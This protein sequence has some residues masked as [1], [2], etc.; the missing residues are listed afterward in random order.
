MN[1]REIG[2]KLADGSFYPVLEQSFI[3]RKKL[4]VTTVRDNQETVQIDLFQGKGAKAEQTDYI[5]SLVIENIH[6][7]PRKEPEIEVVL[8]VDN[9]GNLDATASDSMTGEK[10]SIS[11][12]LTS[13]GA[14]EFDLR[15]ESQPPPQSLEADAFEQSLL[16]GETYPIG[17]SD[18]RKEHLQRKKRS[19]LLLI[20]FILLCLVLIAALAYLVFRLLDGRPIPQLFGGKEVSTAVE[21]PAAPSAGAQEGT[22]PAV[23]A[24]EKPAVAEQKPAAEGPKTP[25]VSEAPKAA[26]IWYMI[27]WGDTLWDL[28]ATYYRNPWLYPQLAKANNIVNPDLIIAGHKL[29][30]P[31]R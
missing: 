17:P 29:F 26:G 28:A 2:I 12:S 11:I 25:V 14:A 1:G 20:G 4:V 19:P 15:E 9:Q 18:R 31:E 8:G 5:G 3:G 27:K 24:E 13:L 6:R 23:S 22:Q 16:T 10:Q 30:I 7:A 21:Q